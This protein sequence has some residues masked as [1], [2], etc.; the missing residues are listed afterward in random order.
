MDLK[1]KLINNV[2]HDLSQTPNNKTPEFIRK[3]I[4]HFAANP[5]N[6]VNLNQEDVEK[7]AKQIE[8]IFCLTM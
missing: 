5:L 6:P 2:I 4:V 7:I 8:Y 1:E 3:L